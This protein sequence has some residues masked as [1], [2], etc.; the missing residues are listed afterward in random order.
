MNKYIC[1][2]RGVNVSGKNILKMDALKVALEDLGFTQVKTYI[3][4]GN[5]VFVSNEVHTNPFETL[6]NEKIKEVFQLDIPVLIINEKEFKAI[7]LANNFLKDS[8]IDASKL[9][10]TFMAQKPLA[11]DVATIASTNFGT[12][13][14]EISSNAI[15]LYCPNGYGN[16]KLTNTFFE[17][18][19]KVNCTTR[20]WNTVLKLAE[21]LG[22]IN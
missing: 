19:L 1:L 5:I 14:F 6:I 20:N 13:Q 9:H 7:I 10:I 15:F 16:T 3:Q 21:M 17:K 4:S 11:S 12:D 8:N 2:L 18:K 22:G